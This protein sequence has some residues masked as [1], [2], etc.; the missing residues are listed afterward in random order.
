MPSKDHRHSNG[1][2]HQRHP[3]IVVCHQRFDDEQQREESH[4]QEAVVELLLQVGGVAIVQVRGLGL[5]EPQDVGPPPA[6]IG[7]MRVKGGVTVQ[8]VV[9]MGG[10]PPERGAA[11]EV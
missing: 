4:L 8:V 1:P 2:A 6:L 11:G 7:G 5:E 10:H 3:T 9:P